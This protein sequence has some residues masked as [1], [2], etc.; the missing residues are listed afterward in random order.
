MRCRGRTVSDATESDDSIGPLPAAVARLPV[1]RWAPPGEL[2]EYR[3]V[4]PLGS[5]GMGSVW[6]AADR[7]LDRMVA[8]KFI[9]HAEPDA[10]TRE[11]FVIEARAAARL[12]HVN[13]VTVYRFGEVAGRP[14]LVSE[15]IRGESLEK[16]DKPLPWQRCLEL[17]VGLA[18][19]S[20]RRTARGSCTVTSSP[21]T[22]IPSGA[23]GAVKLVDFGLARLRSEPGEPGEPGEPAP[24]PASAAALAALAVADTPPELD[25]AGGRS[26]ARRAT[27]AGGAP[28]RPRT[29]AATSTSSAR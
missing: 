13:V 1:R 25:A 3:L 8:I 23:T 19:R 7:L 27:R 26:P 17:G 5:G 9:A 18:Q 20:R 12:A 15:Y 10:S 4:R 16:I 11:R 22:A 24:A 2:E 29:A 21:R 28:A 14:Y 6:L